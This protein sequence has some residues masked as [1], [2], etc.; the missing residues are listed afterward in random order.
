MP[1]QPV[2][3]LRRRVGCVSYLNSKPLIEPLVGRS[4]IYVEFAVPSALSGLLVTGAVDT[5][6]LPIVDYQTCPMELLLVPA[7]CIGC[8]GHTLTVRIFSRVP[9]GE[10]TR[11]FAD[12][13][14]HTSVILAQVI[15]REFYHSSPEILPLPEARGDPVWDA[16]ESVL[17][18]GDK[19]IN[20]APPPGHYPWQLDLGDQWTRNTGLPFVFAMWMMPTSR[21]DAAL[22]RLLAAARLAGAAMTDELVARYAE[23]RGWPPDLLHRYYRHYLDYQ[24]KPASR[25]GIERFYQLAASHNLLAVHRP[26]RYLDMV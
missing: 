15:L 25:E 20:A 26:I 12:T 21:P 17:L 22:A 5:A 24:V 19:V 14:S 3:A 4:D 13:D 1:D 8:H 23:S 16:M 9:P 11:L 7:G 10:I 2:S 6:L 18:I